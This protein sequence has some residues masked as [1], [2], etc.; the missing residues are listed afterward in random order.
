MALELNEIVYRV[1]GQVS[2]RT[3]LPL[4]I[5]IEKVADEC[6]KLCKRYA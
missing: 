2:G 1:K 3:L 5:G 4:P 6:E